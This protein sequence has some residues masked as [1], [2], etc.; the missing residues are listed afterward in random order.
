MLIDP[1]VPERVV[2][3]DLLLLP[4][5][6]M[7]PPDFLLLLAIAKLPR[8]VFT[9]IPRS[10]NDCKHFRIEQDAREKQADQTEHEDRSGQII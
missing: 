4:A 2:L 8:C 9:L 1:L 3:L 7:E 5:L 10:I 6:L